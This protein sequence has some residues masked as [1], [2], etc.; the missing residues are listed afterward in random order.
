MKKLEVNRLL[1]LKHE[2]KVF[3]V[4]RV[5]H[6]AWTYA[7]NGDVHVY[8]VSEPYEYVELLP[9][10]HSDAIGGVA[11]LYSE[12]FQCWNAMTVSW[13]TSVCSWLVHAGP[14]FP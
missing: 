10:F 13:D 3:G 9:N 1:E 14:A 8:S 5:G 4:T 12:K 6:Q 11:A 2:G 7:W